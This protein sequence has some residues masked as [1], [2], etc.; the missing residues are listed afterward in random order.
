MDSSIKDPT[1][2]QLMLL[3]DLTKRTGVLHEIQVTNL[4]LW[5]MIAFTHAQTSEFT[6]DV[7]KHNVTFSLTTK[8]ASPKSMRARFDWLDQSVKALLG[9]EWGITVNMN[10][11]EKF[12]STGKKILNE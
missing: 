7:D 12:S 4:K 5:P 8:G 3:R 2:E 11:K 9:P 6:W 1:W 10:G